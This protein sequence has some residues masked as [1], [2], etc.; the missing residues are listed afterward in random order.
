MS[1]ILATWK[2][3]TG[4]IIVQGHHRQNNTQDPIS[5]TT[6]EKW[7]GSVAQAIDHLL[8]KHEALSSSPRKKKK[9]YLCQV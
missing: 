1:V 5:K 2:A 9:S 3:E 8:Y 6:R 7:T 4:R